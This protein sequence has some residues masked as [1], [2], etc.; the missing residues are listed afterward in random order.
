MQGIT[1][2]STAGWSVLLL[3][4]SL[5]PL[6]ALPAVALEKV[7][8]CHA[9]GLAGTT[10]FVTLVVAPQAL[11]G[12][13]DENG[14]PQ[15]GHEEDY[16]GPCQSEESSEGSEETTDDTTAT[17][18]VTT[19]DTTEDSQGEDSQGEDSQGED[20][21]EGDSQGE[22]SQEE[23]SQGEDT[24]EDSTDTSEDDQPVV[25]PV[26]NKVTDV[27]ETPPTEV[28]AV[29]VSAPPTTTPA[30]VTAAPTVATPAVVAAPAE[31]TVAAAFVAPQTLPFTGAESTTHM[32]Y[33]ASILLAGASFLLAGRERKI[34]RHQAR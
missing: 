10:K 5:I 24:N 16:E 32:A 20:S 34:G 27:E 8:I 3:L 1:R 9:A 19:P 25:I 14:T 33:G 6:L 18:E 15:A 23:D 22:D 7:T 17:T 12:H 2:R 11:S 30:A 21:Q 29:V 4:L 28:A 13:F 31:A 26:D